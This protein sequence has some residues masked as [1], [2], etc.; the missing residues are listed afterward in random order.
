M[1]EVEQKLEQG[2][3]AVIAEIEED[4][5]TPL[6]ARMNALGAVVICKTRSAVMSE[7]IE[8]QVAE[9]KAEMTELKSEI[10]QSVGDAKIRLQSKFD[11]ATTKLNAV[12]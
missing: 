10:G 6:D 12:Q 4:W 7:Q 1:A 3:A 2:K 8:R 9:H 5:V 11:A